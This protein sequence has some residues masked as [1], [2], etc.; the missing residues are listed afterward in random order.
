[1]AAPNPKLRRFQYLL[2]DRLILALLALEGFFLLSER[3]QW[4]A[5]NER[6]GWTVLVAGA[7]VGLA[8]MLTLLWFV[9][10]LFFR[11]RFQFS[12]RSLFV[13]VGSSRMA[14]T[15]CA[16]GPSFSAVF[17]RSSRSLLSMAWMKA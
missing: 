1:M 3:F 5:F 16:K 6:K 15:S 12:I 2:P 13:L 10:S 14:K 11:R 8:I 17:A 4:F 9:L 7:S